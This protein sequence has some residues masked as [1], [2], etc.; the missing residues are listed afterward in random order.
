M[1]EQGNVK[2][3][4]GGGSLRASSTGRPGENVSIRRAIKSLS[5]QRVMSIQGGKK[6]TLKNKQEVSKS[7][8][9]TSGSG[10]WRGKKILPKGGGTSGKRGRGH[11]ASA[12]AD[13]GTRQNHVAIKKCDGRVQILK[14]KGKAL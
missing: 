5:F 2:G 12:R 14:E 11:E 9:V 8:V 1:I 10:L 7:T 6:K 3:T 13:I 4:E